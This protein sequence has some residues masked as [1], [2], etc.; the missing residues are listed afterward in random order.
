[1][2][3]TAKAHPMQALIKYHG[4]RDWEQRI[5]YHDSISVNVEALYTTTRVEF[6]DFENDHALV[7]GSLITGRPLER[8]LTVIDAVRR[9]ASIEERVRVESWNSLPVGSA[10]GLGFSAAAG[11]A[12]AAA[13][14]RAA[15]L[16]RSL[17]WDTRLISRIARKL[18]GSA[19]RSV[20]GEYA[21]WYAGTCDED[22][23][24]ARIAGK[25]ELD[26]AMLIIPFRAELSTEEAHREA[27]LSAFFQ[28]R[29]VSAQRRCDE[30]EA[31]IRGGDLER[32]G[33]LVELDTLEL[34]AVTMTGP[35]RLILT[36]P[37]SLKVVELVKQLR[38]EG[39]ECFYSMQTGPSVFINTTWEDVEY[40]KAQVEELGYRA[41]KSGIGGPAK[42]E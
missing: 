13:A 26:L 20:V 1:M 12:L 5:P 40:V 24:A 6:G 34:H 31:A 4:L 22:S 2:K 9:L 3:A 29:C 19:C 7:D 8:I 38:G 25:N 35:K 16:D 18:A 28:A 27:E 10:K 15:G 21:R 30:L 17:G 11:A 23:Y 33:E 42:A 36:S 41:I 37:D 14:Y 32:F 39:V